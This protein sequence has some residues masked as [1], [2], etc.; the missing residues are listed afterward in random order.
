VRSSAFV[1]VA[2]F[3]PRVQE[4]GSFSHSA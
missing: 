4:V 3:T 1:L 2:Y